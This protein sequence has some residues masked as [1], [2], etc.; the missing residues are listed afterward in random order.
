MRP[1]RGRPWGG[2]AAALVVAIVVALGL[3]RAAAAAPATASPSDVDAAADL[4]RRA[5]L[6]LLRSS[7]PRL[8]A[9]A[10]DADG[11]LARRLGAG[12][13]SALT[14]RQREQLRAGVRERFIRTLAPV[15]AGAAEIAWSGA[16]ATEAGVDAFLGLRFEDR[17]L[18]TRW[19][20]RRFGAGWRIADVVLSDPGVSLA[21]V[22]ENALGPK[23]LDHRTPGQEIWANAL[24]RLAAIAVLAIVAFVVAFRVPPSKRALVYLTAAAPI[25][26]VAIDGGLAISRAVSE[27]YV[28]RAASPAS[29]RWRTLEQLALGADREG[30][31]A[32]ARDYWSQALSAGGPA[33]SIEY[34]IGR[35]ARRSG[36]LEHARAEFERALGEDPPADGAGRELAEMDVQAGRFAE[37]EAR[38]ARYVANTGPDP[39]SLSLLSVVQ[40]NLGRSAQALE[41]VQRARALMG[42]GWRGDEMEARV[43]A[44]AGDAAG[45]VAALRDLERRGAGPIDRSA[46]RSDPSYMPIATDPAWIAFLNEPQPTRPPGGA[47]PRS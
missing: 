42:E 12:A 24:P 35:A 28:V 43:R 2:A 16:Q 27:P 9:E 11:I 6:D 1:P 46:L 29:E 36:D 23:P 21:R 33:G 22:A 31:P 18:K 20:L 38:L 10:L 3:A 32:A 47:D 5:A 39:E 15:R 13:W 45:C 26:L 30:R 14:S 34:Q 40:T 44:R 37:A 41:S 19:V 8:F 17:I 25:T 7:S 4:A